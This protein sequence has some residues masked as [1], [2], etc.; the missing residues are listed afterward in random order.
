VYF[1]LC[2]GTMLNSLAPLHRIFRF[3]DTLGYG[4]LYFGYDPRNMFLAGLTRRKRALYYTCT[5]IVWCAFIP[6]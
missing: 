4:L 6:N 2:N 5:L 3:V 1:L